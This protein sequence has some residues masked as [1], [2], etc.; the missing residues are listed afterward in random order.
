MK[1]DKKKIKTLLKTARGQID[2]VLKMIE[3]DRYCVDINTQLLATQSI[4][5]KVNTEIL[6]A[7]IS[8]CVKETFESASEEQKQAQIKEIISLIGKMTK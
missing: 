6:N 3:D 8:H 7:H 2:G 4:L 1:A 5:K